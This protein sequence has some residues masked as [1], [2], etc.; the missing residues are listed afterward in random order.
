MEEN[1]I[2]NDEKEINNE[3][4]ILNNVRK[5]ISNNDNKKKEIIYFHTLNKLKTDKINPDKEQI[6]ERREIKFLSFNINIQ[7]SKISFKKEDKSKE[8]INEFIKY[9]ND[10]DI[11]C[12]QNFSPGSSLNQYDL[13]NEAVKL[14][15]FFFVTSEIPNL[16]NS[17]FYDSGLI[18]LSRF[19]IDKY[20]FYPFSSLNYNDFYKQKGIL[21]A[22]LKIRKNNLHIFNVSFQ[23][24][25][26]DDN[27]SNCNKV[28]KECQKI[29]KNE[30][31][32]LIKFIKQIVLE[33]QLN[34]NEGDG[35][36]LC[37][38]F[39]IDSKEYINIENNENLKGEYDEM[40]NLFK[41]YKINEINDIF[42]DKRE[43]TYGFNEDNQIINKNFI[44]CNMCVDYIF[45]INQKENKSNFIIDNKKLVLF[46][47]NNHPFT[48]LSD[49]KALSCDI[50]FNFND[51]DENESYHSNYS[52]LTN[53]ITS[54]ESIPDK[55]KNLL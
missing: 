31:E 5:V 27:K 16:F 41:F 55:I 43:S 33:N 22:N 28:I 13:I 1:N 46:P 35:I 2:L 37:G 54:F 30:L 17:S 53:N 45:E 9:L 24:N 32:K 10:Y 6:L 48:F 34:Y 8:R 51:N 38:D 12:F 23:S 25:E 4:N 47:F 14:G 52:N 3:E 39:Q 18:I 15:F 26:Y 49:H 21:Y 42:S 44:G 50:K 19:S 11:I 29:R 40:I 7:K 20:A 36:I